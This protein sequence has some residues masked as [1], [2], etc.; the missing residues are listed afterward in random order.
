M[1]GCGGVIKKL[2]TSITPPKIGNRYVNNG[3]C[4]W[5]IVAPLGYLVQLTFTSF[6]MEEH[7]DCR[8]D[9]LSIYD[10]IVM[11]EN[12]SRP[13]G[14]YCGSSTP[15][16]IISS[17]RALTLFFKSDESLG[18]EGFVATYSFIDG[19]N[20]ESHRSHLISLLRLKYCL[21]VIFFLTVCGGKFYAP[22][23]II[24]SPDYPDEYQSDKDCIF[25]IHAP[26]GKQI[27]L[28]VKS[29]RLEENIACL[30]DF[31]EIRNGGNNKSPLIGNFCGTEIIP[32][33]RS[34]SNMLYLR[35]HTDSSN[36]YSGK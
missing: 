15:P 23:G 6:E 16:A 19:R 21:F 9:Y 18:G 12:G 7:D 11:Q 3:N 33:I 29:F 14:K 27:D 25:I 2:N 31:L 10:N 1:I 26:N 36:Q 24:R 4:K 35:F 28:H 30:F 22:T 13:I 5:I 34:F 17:S 8:L 32:N 20:G